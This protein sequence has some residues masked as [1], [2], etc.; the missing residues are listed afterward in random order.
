MSSAKGSPASSLSSG[1]RPEG[2]AVE[3][4]WMVGG[5]GGERIFAAGSGSG[6]QQIA[7]TEKR[8]GKARR[9]RVGRLIAAAPDLLELAKL[10]EKSIRYQIQ[11]VGK[12]GDHEGARMMTVTLNTVVLPAIAKA[13][14]PA[15]EPTKGGE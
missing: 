9:A 13:L 10:F 15:S 4:D 1:G 2:A 11:V 7:V 6:Y 14:P 5:P 12:R 3:K 8:L